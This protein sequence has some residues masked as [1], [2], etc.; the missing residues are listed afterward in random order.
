MLCTFCCQVWLFEELM[1]VYAHSHTYS[2]LKNYCDTW[3]S[4]FMP[5]IPWYSTCYG[6]HDSTPMPVECL[7]DIVFTGGRVVGHESTH[8]IMAHSS[9]HHPYTILTQTVL[10][11]AQTLCL[12][13]TRLDKIHQIHLVHLRSRSIKRSVS[14][15]ST[16]STK[17][18]SLRLIE[19][20]RGVDALTLTNDWNDTTLLICLLN[21]KLWQVDHWK[22]LLVSTYGIVWI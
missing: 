8:A 21:D 6:S 7:F 15:W 17:G 5:C 16:A 14:W 4:P 2:S 20:T 12:C 18:H 11:T 19:D 9:P 1:S 3:S 10:K 22:S 13:L